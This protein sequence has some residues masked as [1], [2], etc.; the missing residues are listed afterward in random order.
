MFREKLNLSSLQ[1]PPTPLDYAPDPPVS[2]ARQPSTSR[3]T[4]QPSPE[5]TRLTDKL[6]DM[7]FEKLVKRMDVGAIDAEIDECLEE[8]VRGIQS[9][10]PHVSSATTLS[11]ASKL[12]LASLSVFCSQHRGTAKAYARLSEQLSLGTQRSQSNRRLCPGGTSVKISRD[13]FSA[14]IDCRT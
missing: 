9:R 7:I 12:E 14:K 6:S 10:Q 3:A 13:K 4:E 8:N 1:Q 2:D 5:Q 11:P